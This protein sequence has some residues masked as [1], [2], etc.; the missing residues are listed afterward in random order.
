MSNWAT[1][2]KVNEF[3]D[4]LAVSPVKQ[5]YPTS[6]PKYVKDISLDLA[7]EYLNN[8]CESGEL[9]LLWEVKCSSEDFCIRELDKVPDKSHVLD[10]NYRCDICGKIT[11]VTNHDI[12][13]IFEIDNEYK[14][15]MRD[16]FKKKKLQKGRMRLKIK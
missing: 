8:L 7:F 14:S 5:F 1:K 6:V 13:P 12:Y 3:V 15:Y 10:K 9:H 11:C 4:L 2:K 16:E